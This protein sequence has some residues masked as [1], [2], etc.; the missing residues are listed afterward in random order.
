MTTDVA[1]TEQ[2]LETAGEQASPVTDKVLE[3]KPST[4]AEA[5]SEVADWHESEEYKA[6]AKRLADEAYRRGQGEKDRLVAQAKEGAAKEA[7]EARAL[8]ETYEARLREY[9]EEDDVFEL[10]KHRS[11]EAAAQAPPPDPNERI[12][13]MLA[14]NAQGIVALGKK[15]GVNLVTETGDFAPDVEF[16]VDNWHKD[17]IAETHRLADT[18]ITKAVK[19]AVAEAAKKHKAEMDAL[20]ATYEGKLKDTQRVDTSEP[21]GA[22]PRSFAAKESAYNSGDI[23]WEEFNKARQEYGLH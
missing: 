6:E 12:N 5:S 2:G 19:T 13:G 3:E 7:R 4:E 10:A 16:S 9:G 1:A 20:K 8:A 21:N 22:S 11:R 17:P 14:A 23:S 18:M 15:H